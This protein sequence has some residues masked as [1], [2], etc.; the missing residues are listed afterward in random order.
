MTRSHRHVDGSLALELD[1]G[2]ASARRLETRSGAPSSLTLARADKYK[3]LEHR[4]RQAQIRARHLLD[5]LEES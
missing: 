4:R 2:P 5:L 3:I 1:F